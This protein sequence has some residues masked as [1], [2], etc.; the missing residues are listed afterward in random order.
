MYEFNGKMALSKTKIDFR[1]CAI[2]CPQN[3]LL[4]ISS[5]LELV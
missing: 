4:E 2:G 5:G 1:A 3:M